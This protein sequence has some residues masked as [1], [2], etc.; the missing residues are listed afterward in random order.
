MKTSQEGL[1]F[2]QDLEGTRYVA[3]QDGGGVW[4]NGVGHTGSD[5]Y[6]GQ[7]VDQKQVMKWL[8]EDVL[9]AE[10]AV[11]KV[12]VPLT[13]NQYDA[14]VSFVFNIGV[15]AFG[16]STLLRLLNNGDYEGA[17]K[18]FHRWNKDNGKVVPGLTKRRHL[19]ASLFLR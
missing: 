16:K 3:Y 11:D 12:K 13:Q 1:E 9:E 8:A 7:R 15:G 17:A 2:L 18:Q 10:S 4:T 6:P 14:L 19:E 5:V